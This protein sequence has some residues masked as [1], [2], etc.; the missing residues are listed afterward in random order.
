MNDSRKK[1]S[2]V[3]ALITLVML[4]SNAFAQGVPSPATPRLMIGADGKLISATNPLPVDVAGGISVTI[5][6]S[7]FTASPVYADDAGTSTLGLTDSERRVVVNIGSETIGLV[8]EVADL[9]AQQATETADTISAIDSVSHISDFATTVQVVTVGTS[10][11]VIMPAL[12]TARAVFVYSDED[13]NFGGSGIGTGEAAPYIPGE[14]P[15]VK[16]QFGKA[17]PAFYFRGRTA[18]ATVQIWAATE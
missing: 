14:A 15:F 18:T 13:V 12:G 4:C 6:S 3:L 2:I 8:D 16:F 7:T 10:A 9:A 5:G 17:D 1:S 11:A